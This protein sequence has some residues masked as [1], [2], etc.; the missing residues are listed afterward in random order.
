MRKWLDKMFEN[1]KLSIIVPIAIALLMYVLF[2]LFGTADNKTNIMM[3]IPIVSV[4]AF[5]GVFFVVFVQ[6][7]NDSCPEWFLNICELLGAIIFGVS[8]VIETI[9]FIFSGFQNFTIG[10]CLG[11]VS[12]SAISWAH[13]KRTK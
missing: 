11:L 10:I 1:K 5:F 13:S 12:Y 2:I 6:V 9:S 4:F 3:A 8:A 7:K